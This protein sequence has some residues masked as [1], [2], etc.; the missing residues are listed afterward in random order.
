M[1]IIDSLFEFSDSQAVT[2]VTAAS[3]DDS[4]YVSDLTGG[5]SAKDG[6][7]KITGSSSNKI[8]DMFRGGTV[9]FNVRVDSAGTVTSGVKLDARLMVHSAKSSVKSGNELCRIVMPNAATA[10]TIRT[11]SVPQVEFAYTERY[12]GIAYYGTGSTVTT[13]TVS[14]WL[15]NIPGDTQITGTTVT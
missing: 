1:A 9:Y 12:C 13:I 7:Y 8:G 15:S 2:S 6:W 3:A 5:N 14:A 10:G 4:T 11:V